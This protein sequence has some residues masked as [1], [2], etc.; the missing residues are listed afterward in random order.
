MEEER[1]HRERADELE[2]DADRVEQ[3]SDELERDI[4]EAR[5][6]WKAKQSDPRAPGALDEDS[7]GPDDLLAEGERLAEADAEDDPDE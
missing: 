4:G 5:S 6:D 2:Q 7:T 3:A 1:E